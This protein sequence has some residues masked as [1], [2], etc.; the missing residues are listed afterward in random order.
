MRHPRFAAWNLRIQQEDNLFP[1]VNLSP[2]GSL[3]FSQQ[4]AGAGEKGKTVCLS[5]PHVC[6][7]GPAVEGPGGIC[8]LGDRSARV[9]KAVNYRYLNPL[10]VSSGHCVSVFQIM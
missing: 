9:V 10:S 4:K 8:C 7:S 6:D 1:R 3:E 2:W 5:K